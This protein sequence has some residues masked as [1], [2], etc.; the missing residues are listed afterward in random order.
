MIFVGDGDSSAYRSVCALNAGKGPYGD[1]YKVIKEECIN[2]IQKMMVSRLVGLRKRF[3]QTVTT[4]T[5]RLISR[6]QV[7]GLHKLSDATIK[8]I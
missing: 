4:S 6:S 8:K 2:H 3:V 7:G 1:D 5:G